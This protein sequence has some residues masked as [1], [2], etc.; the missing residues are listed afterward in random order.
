MEL[1][2]DLVVERHEGSPCRARG[3]PSLE[4]AQ[5]GPPKLGPVCVGVAYLVVR[6]R[7]APCTRASLEVVQL[8]RRMA[9]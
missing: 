7:A 8:A 1:L 5:A 2:S 9:A 4:E 3:I 6:P